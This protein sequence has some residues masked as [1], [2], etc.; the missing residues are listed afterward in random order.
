MRSRTTE[1]QSTRLALPPTFYSVTEVI[2]RWREI[3]TFAEDDDFQVELVCVGVGGGGVVVGVLET[4]SEGVT[5]VAIN[6]A[7][8]EAERVIEAV[9][10]V[11]EEGVIKVEM[12][13]EDVIEGDEVGET[14][15]YGVV[16]ASLIAYCR[17]GVKDSTG[18]IK[19]R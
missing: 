5:E 18:F 11:I 13:C 17:P 2:Y 12:D 7:E 14:E 15:E 1:I 19:T 9:G 6:E 10:V 4:D 3:L 8:M 16:G